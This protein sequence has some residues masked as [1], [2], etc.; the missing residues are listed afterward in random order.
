MIY[1]HKNNTLDIRG[2]TGYYYSNDQ[3]IFA[4][5]GYKA[6]LMFIKSSNNNENV[7]AAFKNQLNQREECR[8]KKFSNKKNEE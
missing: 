8:L 1:Q 7:I 4:G 3:L 5:D 6:I 2:G